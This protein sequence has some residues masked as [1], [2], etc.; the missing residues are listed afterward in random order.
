M[1]ERGLAGLCLAAVLLGAAVP[2]PASSC[3]PALIGG[4]PRFEIRGALVLDRAS[5]LLWQRCSVGQRHEASSGRCV[6]QPQLL[7][8]ADA[9]IQARALGEGWRLPSV[10]ELRSLVD[11]RCGVPAIDPQAFP[12]FGYPPQQ[13]MPYWTGTPFETVPGMSYHVDFAAGDV[14]VRTR[15]FALGVLPVRGSR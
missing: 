14:D 8:H 13:G 1:R 2:A 5:G 15:G 9:R 7:R 10:N 6:G 12:G 11:P 4:Q 3:P